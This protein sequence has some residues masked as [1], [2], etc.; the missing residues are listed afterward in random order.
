MAASST[1]G[2][3]RALVEGGAM[4]SGDSVDQE[5]NEPVLMRESMKLQP[6]Q[7]EILKGKTKPLFGESTHMMVAPLKADQAQQ[8]KAWP[9]Y[10]GLHA[11]TRLKMGSNRYMW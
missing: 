11:H 5:I 3:G 1:E 9:L 2:M 8:R 6:F 4:E 7:M 10:P